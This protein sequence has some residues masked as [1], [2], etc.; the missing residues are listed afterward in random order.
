MRLPYSLVL[1][2]GATLSAQAPTPADW[3]VYGGGPESMRYSALQ[4]ITRQNV[5]HL[6]VAWT[7]DAS[8]GIPSSE[9]EVNPIVVNGVLYATTVRLTTVALKAAT[10]ELLWRFDPYR[11]RKVRGE[12][13]RT[14]GV[15][16]WGD[17]PDQR[18]F[19]AV[20]QF[21][22]ALD[23]TTGHPIPSFGKGGRIDM[24]DGLRP[25]EKLMVSLGTPGIVY[26]NLL[27]IGSRTAES[28]P[29]PPGDGKFRAFDK[30]TGALLWETTLPAAGNATPATYEVDGRQF[31]VIATSSGKSRAQAPATYVA[32]ALDEP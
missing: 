15:V 1:L 27:I 28:L 23:A 17:G 7:F 19:V 8:D 24:R 25:G 10:G 14:R 29:T 2:A 21:L 31:V 6:K 18:I 26:R 32:F 13:G 11:G 12:G 22:Y 5:T 4:Q 3:P 9:L 30:S 20:Q 16:H